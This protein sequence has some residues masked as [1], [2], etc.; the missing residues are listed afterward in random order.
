MSEVLSPDLEKRLR[1]LEPPYQSRGET[2]IG[3]VLDRYGIPFFYRQPT[4]IYDG[5][6][7]HLWHP[8]FTLPTYNGLVIEYARRINTPDY[9]RGIERKRL[10]YEA[11]EVPAVFVY[12]EDLATPEWPEDLTRRIEAATVPY[13]QGPYHRRRHPL[14]D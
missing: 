2:E 13:A 4:L 8:D 3:R 12:P 5:G 1:A 10:V 6:R 7:H 11:N 9:V 14:Y